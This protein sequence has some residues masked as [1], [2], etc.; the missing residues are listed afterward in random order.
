MNHRLRHPLAAV[1]AEDSGCSSGATCRCCEARN[2]ARAIALFDALPEWNSPLTAGIQLAN[3]SHSDDGLVLWAD[4]GADWARMFSTLRLA[5][6]GLVMTRNEAA[7]LGNRTVLPPLHLASNGA[8]AAGDGGR[9]LVDF[10]HLATARAVHIRR[11]IGHV[12]GVEFTDAAGH[13]IHRFT[14]TP[15]SDMDEFFA[16]VR[17]HQACSAHS[18]EVWTDDEEAD[19]TM[20][21]R[22]AHFLQECDG[23]AL[24]LIVSACIDRAIPLRAAV[25]NVAVT[26]RAEF[27]PRA[28][29]VTDEWRFASDDTHGL[30][31]QPNGF[32]QVSLEALPC[33]SRRLR[34][35]PADGAGSLVLEAG[36]PAAEDSWRLILETLA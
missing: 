22:P 21:S 19:P 8:K 16:W 23:E 4:L 29:Q 3:L 5:G 35:I 36:S 11:S 17:L 2:R 31:F 20:P 33:Q 7:I 9:L 13:T 34:A 26:Q 25:R 14:L 1:T 6:T 18:S 12:F 30:H 27:I 24:E 32:G 15:E 28:L 10:R